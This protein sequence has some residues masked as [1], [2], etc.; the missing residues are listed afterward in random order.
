MNPLYLFLADFRQGGYLMSAI[1]SVSVVAW[2]IGIRKFLLLRKLH[3]ARKRFLKYAHHLNSD[4]PEVTVHTGFEHYDQLLNQLHHTI[5]NNG[6]GC[7]GY[8]REFLIGTVPFLN[9]HF[10]TMS[11]WISVAPLLGLLGTV[12]GMIQTFRVI[13][14]FGIGNPN[15]TAEGISIALLTT[16]AGLTSAF[17]ALIFHNFLINRKDSLVAHM[18]NDCEMLV[19]DI[20]V[21]VTT[22]DGATNV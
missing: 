15:L 3:N 2:M 19:N 5:K 4:S 7:K 12:M 11:A 22:S 13:M 9:R 21:K 14:D 20:T 6:I 8:M 1:F 10:S 18:L 17:P 16:Q